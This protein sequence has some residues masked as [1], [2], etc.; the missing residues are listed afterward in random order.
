MKYMVIRI[1]LVICTIFVVNVPAFSD[2]YVNRNIYKIEDITSFR[3]LT[4]QF[5]VDFDKKRGTKEA[6]DA[7][8]EIMKYYYDFLYKQS[9]NINLNLLFYNGRDE[10]FL[11]YQNSLYFLGLMLWYDEGSCYF[12]NSNRYIYE[13]FAPYLSIE[14]QELLKFKIFYDSC[15]ASHAKYILSKSELRNIIQFYKN[16][17][18]KYP[19]FSKEYGIYEVIKDYEDDLKHYSYF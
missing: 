11:K 10:K 17:S 16:F 19:E 5:Q 7:Y 13:N 1:L 18:K 14:M 12:A 2:G 6:E 8:Y 15:V 3:A 9:E 4:K